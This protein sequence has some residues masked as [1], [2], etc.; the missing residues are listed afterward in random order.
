MYST[1]HMLIP[2]YNEADNLPGLLDDLPATLDKLPASWDLVIVD[3]GSSD[4][5]A[6]IVQQTAGRTHPVTLVRHW[7]NLGPGAAFMTGF[8]TI[9]QT[10]ADDDPIVT[11]EAD[12]TSDLEILPEML[13]RFALGADVVLASV[14]HPEGGLLHTPPL[15]RALSSG[16]NMIM[17]QLFQMPHISTFSSFYRIYRAATLRKATN[18]YGLRLMEEP[19]FA[20]VVELLLRLN[21]V[22]AIIEEVPMI[23]DSTKRKGSSRMKIGRTVRAY[24]RMMLRQ[25][26]EPVPPEE[27]LEERNQNDRRQ[28]DRKTGRQEDR[29][30][31]Y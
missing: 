1:I 22:G 25:R 24:L 15:R 19:G 12:G 9:L 29:K 16:A 7:R 14:Y 18:T 17:K 4:R 5:T 2:A 30:T 26:L 3:D 11:L 10:A 13:S 6:T 28:K 27:L 21:R 31:G 20:A 8:R 23:L